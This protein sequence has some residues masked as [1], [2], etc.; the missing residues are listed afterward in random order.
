[1]ILAWDRLRKGYPHSR[2]GACNLVTLARAGAVAVL[3]VA[4]VVP[5]TLSQL[6]WVICALAALAL[7][8]DG[9]DGKLARRA[10]LSSAFGARFDMEVDAA[11]AACLALILMRAEGIDGAL[12]GLCLLVLGGSRYAFVAAT[13][14]LP[15]M[16]R[17]LPERFTRKTVCVV[18]IATLAALIPVGA[19]LGG[20]AVAAVVLP[21]SAALLLWSFGRDIRW[22]AMR[23]DEGQE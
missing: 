18:Q 3:S 6:P 9:V 12:A 21:V 16:A 22:L 2:L 1:M 4:V 13:Q 8:L 14:L 15:W 17:P 10:G 5:A 7:A 23:R 11:L 20:S 19:G